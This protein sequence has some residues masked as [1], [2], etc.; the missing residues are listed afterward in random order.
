MWGVRYCMYAEKAVD[1]IHTHWPDHSMQI[2]PI[3]SWERQARGGQCLPLSP[4]V[5]C[6]HLSA[7][8][9]WTSHQCHG[10]KQPG[11]TQALQHGSGGCYAERALQPRKRAGTH[12]HTFLHGLAIEWAGCGG[13]SSL[14]IHGIQHFNCHQSWQCHSHGLGVIKDIAVQAFKPLILNQALRLMCLQTEQ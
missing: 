9:I 3:H 2:N 8:F 5:V 13:H 11:R 6:A 12:C 10:C 14:P 7:C 4:T 1:L